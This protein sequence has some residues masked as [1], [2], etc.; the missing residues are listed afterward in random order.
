MLPQ[1]VPVIASYEAA[2]FASLLPRDTI[3]L[4]GNLAQDRQSE[5]LEPLFVRSS[6]SQE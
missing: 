4:K 3:E 6:L 2:S 1:Q 5:D